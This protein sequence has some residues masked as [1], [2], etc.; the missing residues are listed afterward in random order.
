MIIYL[1]G[2]YIHSDQAKISVFDRGFLF[3]DS[4][5]EVIAVYDGNPF[6]LERHLNRLN[7]SLADL[8]ISVK[9]KHDQWIDIFNQLISK[10]NATKKTYS[11]YLQI[12]RGAG[13]DRNYSIPEKSLTPTIFAMISENKIPDTADYN[14]GFKVI[15]HEDLRWKWS[16]IKTTQLL[17]NI[18]LLDLAKQ[19]DATEV[20][21]IR[22]GKAL[23][24]TNSNFFIVKK[25]ILITPPLSEEML[26]GTTRQLILDLAK[27]NNIPIQERE[28][29]KDELYQADELWITSSPREIMPIIQCDN[30]IIG[31]GKPGHIWGKIY[32]NFAIQRYLNKSRHPAT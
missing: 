2:Q 27:K 23:E 14:K 16:H 7:Q 31:N 19:N 9:I 8:K 24:G 4:V 6:Q 18:L 22:D 32:K 21:L 17:P 20:I 11:I 15:T 1:N 3:A 30:K 26:S 28:I 29:L 12:T 13:E 25:G 5:Y 10:N